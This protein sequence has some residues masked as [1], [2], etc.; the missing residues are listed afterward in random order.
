MQKEEL[1]FLATGVGLEPTRHLARESKSRMSIQFHHPA[2][3]GGSLFS[4]TKRAIIKE[5]RYCLSTM[6]NQI[7]EII[8]ILFRLVYELISSTSASIASDSIDFATSSS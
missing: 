2:I 3:F 4:A 1:I 7:F 5:R 6:T 8:F